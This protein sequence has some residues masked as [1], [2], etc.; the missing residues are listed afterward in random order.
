MRIM[1]VHPFYLNVRA[2]L[3]LHTTHRRNGNPSMA[4]SIPL[5][6]NSYVSPEVMEL[7]GRPSTSVET[8][9]DP[10]VDKYSNKIT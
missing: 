5:Q 6:R 8:L 7:V 3:A 2:A 9:E 10:C 1:S 4:N